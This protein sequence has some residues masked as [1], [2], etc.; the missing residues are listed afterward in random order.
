MTDASGLGQQGDKGLLECRGARSR[1][2]LGWGS[3]GEHAAIIHG[4]QLVE[5]F[6]L[7]H[8]GGGD[9]HA[10]PRASGTHALHQ[11]PELPT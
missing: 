2:N 10:H 6:R 9:D 3:G 8:V 5:A 11:F 1:P 4:D 7:F